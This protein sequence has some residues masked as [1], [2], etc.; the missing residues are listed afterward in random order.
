LSYRF[1]PRYRDLHKKIDAIVGA[2]RCDAGSNC[3]QAK[4]L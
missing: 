2:K 4:Q 3:A 1:T